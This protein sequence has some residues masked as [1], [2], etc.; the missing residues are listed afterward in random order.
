VVTVAKLSGY[1]GKWLRWEQGRQLTGYDKMLL[2]AG[3]FPVP[4]DCY[5]LRFPEGS[6]ISPHRDP[7]TGRRHY[8]LNIILK[9]SPGGGDF[10]CGDPIVDYGRI[11]FFRSDVREHSVTRVIGGRRY[12]LSVGWT[13]R[14]RSGRDVTCVG[15]D[16]DG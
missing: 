11:K 15:A 2:L 13:L 14:R 12:V 3:R 4:F 7:V 6:E 8:S 9:K 10:V 1:V 16:R 5:L